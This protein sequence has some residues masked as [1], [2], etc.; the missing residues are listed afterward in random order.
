VRQNGQYFRSRLEQLATVPPELAQLEQERHDAQSGVERDAQDL[1][2]ATRSAE[3]ALSLSKQLERL[4]ERA[5]QLTE[6]ASGLRTGYDRARHEA[7]RQ[8]VAELEV[9]AV[10]AQRL[11]ADAERLPGLAEAL[12]AA[13][14][15]RG[16]QIEELA[17]LE[18][19]LAGMAFTEEA[20]QA[21]SGEMQRL[22]AEW[23][24]AEQDVAVAKAELAAAAE[25]L[26]DADQKAQE[27]A[28]RAARAADVQ[29]TL[30]LHNELDRAFD[31]LRT[32]LNQE[33]RPELAALAAE[34]LASLTDGRYDELSLDED[35]RATVLEDGAPQTVISGGEEDLM[36]LVIR[37]A[38]SQ[39][40]AERA[41][42]PFSLLVLDEIFGS[43]DD[44]R[45]EQV[46]QLLRALEA[47]FPQVI[48]IT[49]IESVRERL[50]R[51][52]RVR[53]DEAS[54][55]AVV[56]EERAPLPPPAPDEHRSGEAA[57]GGGDDANVAA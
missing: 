49:H 54:G 6:Q 40:I 5:A 17:T 27:A 43:L 33:L 53:F 14:A 22:E 52:I 56:A 48:L 30:R 35:Y 16:F 2:V 36:N 12:G 24:S 57:R 19:E 34:F 38:V 4:R 26:H 1:A 44:A 47:R 10:R 11:A 3:E 20:F 7:A 25:R 41:G 8:R 21:A 50:D 39:M 15:R 9:R 32:E 46:V 51:V 37:F 13:E 42:Q 23:R 45:R 28:A 55:S 31:D 29:L 18:R